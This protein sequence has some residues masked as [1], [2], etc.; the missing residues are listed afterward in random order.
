MIK[1]QMVV[2]R[3]SADD[4]FILL[5]YCF[6]LK[7]PSLNLGLQAALLTKPT[8]LGC[9]WSQ[10]VAG[11]HQDKFKEAMQSHRGKYHHSGS[12]LKLTH[13]TARVAF[14]LLIIH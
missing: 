14:Q 1:G 6:V 7:F 3:G 4:T 9:L 13:T 10:P 2:R 12:D 11:E 8:N 5:I